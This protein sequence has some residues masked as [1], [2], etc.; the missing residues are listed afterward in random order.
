LEGHLKERNYGADFGDYV[1]FARHMKHKAGNMG[2]DMLIVDTGTD[3]TRTVMDSFLLIT[4]LG[5]LH[6]GTGLS[7]ATSPDGELSNKVFEE[8]DYDLLSI[9]KGTL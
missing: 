4:A 6:D 3:I 9:G 2:V 8:L 1:S 5:D 7:D